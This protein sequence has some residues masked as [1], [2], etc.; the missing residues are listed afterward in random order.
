MLIE[1][2]DVYKSKTVKCT[3]KA[4]EIAS[5]VPHVNCSI[6]RQA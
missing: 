4:V 3:G 1:V 5:I 2:N 6:Y